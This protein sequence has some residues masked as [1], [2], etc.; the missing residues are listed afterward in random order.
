M[1]SDTA[2]AS[3]RKLTEQFGQQ[4]RLVGMN[5]RSDAVYVALRRRSGTYWKQMVRC[6]AKSSTVR[7]VTLSKTVESPTVFPAI[8][9]VAKPV[10]ATDTAISKEG[11]SARVKTAP[12]ESSELE[13]ELHSAT[14]SPF[15]DWC[16]ARVA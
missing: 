13:S 12:V 16:P 4:A 8:V 15:R 3:R 6:T 14:H 7:L 10:Q 11:R 2:V 9:D 1:Q 5:S